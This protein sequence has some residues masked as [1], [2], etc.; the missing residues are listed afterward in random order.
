L[1]RRRPPAAPLLLTLV[2]TGACGLDTSGQEILAGE[3]GSQT[4]PHGGD[5]ASG[6]GGSTSGVLSTS[7]SGSSGGSGG[8]DGGDIP[9]APATITGEGSVPGTCDFNGTWAS[10]ITIDVNW[11]PQGLNSIILASGSGKI[12]QW[13]RG[14]RVVS[15]T[16]AT[17]KT[18]VCGVVLPD[19][20]STSL[21]ASETYGVVFPS[22]LF[23]GTDIPSFTVS[24]TISSNKP[25]ATY[26]TM[27]AAA[28]IGISMANPT[29]DA[30]PSAVTTAVDM[31]GDG[32]PG[33]TINVASGVTPDAGVYSGV[34]VGIPAFGQPTVRADKLYVSIRQVTIANAM[35]KDCTHI[36]GSVTIP[37]IS[38][39]VGIDSHVLGCELAAGGDCSTTATFP[40]TSQANFVDNTQPVFTPTGTATIESVRVPPSTKCSA[41]RQML[42]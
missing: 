5:D 25:G 18:V 29:S 12:E 34:P 20:Q 33:V 31:D 28:L 13:I 11:M 24:A 35:A 9:D 23:E 8:D 27:P 36:S 30:W 3:D 21:A 16:T 38:G 2:A 19:F 14:D 22:P 39:K 37:S 15:G 32:K 1:L 7:G 17:D 26:S 4:G 41:V 42:P 10:H 6:Y 40:A